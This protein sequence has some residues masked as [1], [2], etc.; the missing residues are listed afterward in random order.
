MMSDSEWIDVAKGLLKAE[1]KR[2]NL[3]YGDLS[4]RLLEIGVSET[5]RNINNKIARGKFTF[6]FALQCLSAMKCET[7]RI[8]YVDS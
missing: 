1:V 3:T 8:D 6:V 2:R 5:P 7:L 4:Q